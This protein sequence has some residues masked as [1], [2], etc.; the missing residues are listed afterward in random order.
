[1]KVLEHLKIYNSNQDCL[2]LNDLSRQYNFDALSADILYSNT[3]ITWQNEAAWD[4]FLLN[5]SKFNFIGILNC[6][7]NNIFCNSIKFKTI[8]NGTPDNEYKGYDSGYYYPFFTSLN[9]KNNYQIDIE[10]RSNILYKIFIQNKNKNSLSVLD[11]SNIEKFDYIANLKVKKIILSRY[12]KSIIV[13]TN[14][15][16]ETQN[17]SV[18]WRYAKKVTFNIIYENI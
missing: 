13:P 11:I 5:L 17:P 15:D 18:V 4:G 1:M 8:K 16:N 7:S 6:K 2:I 3:S 14:S 10:W 9:T 12:D